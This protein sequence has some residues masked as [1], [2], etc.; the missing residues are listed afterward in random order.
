MY[1]TFHVRH[2]I[3]CALS[4]SAVTMEM[5]QVSTLQTSLIENLQHI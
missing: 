1:L 2:I 3:P 4:L 5:K